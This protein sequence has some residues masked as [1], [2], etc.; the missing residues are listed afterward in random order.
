MGF[1]GF[2]KKDRIIDLGERYRKQQERIAQKKEEANTP[3]NLNQEENS[4][5]P[6]AF[7]FLGNLASSN[8][9]QPDGLNNSSD[10]KKKKF[11]KRLV[12]MTDKLEELSNQIYHLQQ[13]VEL[14]EKKTGTKNY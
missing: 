4:P 13:R 7:S 5:S 9:E 11:A 10:D 12:D 3:S 1:L 6:G 2:G 14:L 8:S